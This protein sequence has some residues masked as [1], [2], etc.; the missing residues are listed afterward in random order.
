MGSLQKPEAEF[1]E[2]AEFLRKGKVKVTAGAKRRGHYWRF[3]EGNSGYIWEWGTG[4]V[5]QGC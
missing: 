1:S 5:T 3:E 4:E 2:W